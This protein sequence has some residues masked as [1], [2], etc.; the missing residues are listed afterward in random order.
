MF[1]KRV[2]T[3]LCAL[4]V[5][6]AMTGQ[7]QD[8]GAASAPNP[9]DG[10]QWVK[11]EGITLTWTVGADAIL[12]DIYF[13][14]DQA[15]VEAR[16]ASTRIRTMSLA[17]EIDLDVLEPATT[18]YWAVDEMSST[19]TVSAGAVWSFTTLDPADG[20]AMAEYWANMSL[21]GEPDV[22]KVVPEVN[23]EWGSG[24]VPGE[25]SPDAAIAVDG[26]SCR[27]TAELTIPTSGAYTF[28]SA[29]DDGA[30]L[31]L[32]GVQITDGWYDRGTTEDASEPQELEAGGV[33]QLVMEMYENGGGAAAF[34]RWEGPGIAKQ[35]IPQGALQEPKMAFSPAPRVGAT[36]VEATPV[37][38]WTAGEGAVAHDVYLGTDADLV[39][40]GDPHAYP[41]RGGVPRFPIARSPRSGAG[42]LLGGE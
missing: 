18:Y 38:S 24:T 21:D 14:T 28:Y 5:S 4:V 2:V 9:A 17:T 32:N 26:F 27:W 41:G 15:A 35:I 1:S 25:N 29:S 34:L 6:L 31:F 19:M 12:R 3:V 20:G 22:V 23:F 16:D 42:Y 37:L 13:G 36:K 10:A 40:A 30:R 7:A 11:T 33:Y 39:A 8:P